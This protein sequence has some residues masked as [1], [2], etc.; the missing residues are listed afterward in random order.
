MILYDVTWVDIST[1]RAWGQV[2]QPRT[3]Q[4][5]PSRNASPCTFAVNLSDVVVVLGGWHIQMHCQGASPY[6]AKPIGGRQ[7]VV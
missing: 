4:G 1:S 5:W 7:I 3:G 2:A 6:M